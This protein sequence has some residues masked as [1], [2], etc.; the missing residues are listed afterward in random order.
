M[1]VNY[2]T[3]LLSKLLKDIF[4]KVIYVHEYD[5]RKSTTAQIVHSKFWNC[6][7]SEY[8]KCLGARTLT[9]IL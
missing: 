2:E 5:T 4:V 9:F 1:Y 8:V 7:Y 3:D 6:V